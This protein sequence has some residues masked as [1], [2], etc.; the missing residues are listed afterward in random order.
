MRHG[1]ANLALPTE[2][3]E[4]VGR[5]PNH[6]SGSAFVKKGYDLYKETYDTSSPAM[7]GKNGKVFEG[8]ILAVLQDEG[9]IPVY[10]QARISFVPNVIYDILLY[11]SRRPVI[12]S[13]KVSLRERWKQA[14]LEGMALRQVYRAASSYLLTLSAAEGRRV[15]NQVEKVEVLGIDECIVIQSQNDRFDALINSL[16]PQ[17]FMEAQAIV[18]VT[19]SV[20]RH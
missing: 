16:K 14:D 4:V 8:L 2:F 20:L 5:I 13:C 15:Q 10:H 18:P 6:L 1:F 3:Y 11:H 7:R 12:L 19:G 17:T 9:I